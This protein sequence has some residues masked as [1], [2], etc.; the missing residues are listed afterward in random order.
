METFGDDVGEAV[1]D[2]DLDADVRK[3]LLEPLNCGPEDG[4][5]RVLARDQTDGARGLV[6]QPVSDASAS[7]IPS[8]CGP[9]VSSSRCPASASDTL[10]VVRVNNRTPRPSSRP[11]TVWLKADGETPSLAA[12]LAK[13]RSR[14]TARKAIRAL[15]FSRAIAEFLS[16]LHAH[17]PA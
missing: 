1:V 11:L 17:F 4:F 10:R 16:A 12:P 8:K 14:A 9:I 13:L 7:S 15:S 3:F 2:G 6:A 5:G